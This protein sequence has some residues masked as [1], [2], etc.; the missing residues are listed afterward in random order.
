MIHYYRLLA[1]LVYP[2]VV[3]PTKTETLQM[4]HEI[5]LEKECLILVR[6]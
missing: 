5:H 1:Q 4:Q 2:G 6:V 3:S